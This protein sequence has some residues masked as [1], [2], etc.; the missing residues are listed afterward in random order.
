M[1]PEGQPDWEYLGCS[2]GSA[3]DSNE[4]PALLPASSDDEPQATEQWVPAA[5]ALLQFCATLKIPRQTDAKVLS[6]TNPDH[7]TLCDKVFLQTSNFF[8]IVSTEGLRQLIVF[9]KRHSRW[10]IS[11]NS[12]HKWRS[13]KVLLGF[14]RDLAGPWQIRSQGAWTHINLFFTSSSL[15]KL[16]PILVRTALPPNV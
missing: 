7:P 3:S 15:Q 14:M 4:G 9:N 11:Q 5:P 13:T 8:R 2:D 6:A 12:V 1:S 16:P 10:I